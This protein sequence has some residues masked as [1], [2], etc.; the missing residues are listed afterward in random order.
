MALKFKKLD[1]VKI[2]VD[3]DGVFHVESPDWSKKMVRIPTDFVIGR[4]GVKV[5]I[6]FKDSE[7]KLIFPEPHHVSQEE[8]LNAEIVKTG[9]KSYRLI[10]CKFWI[11]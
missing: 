9:G 8:L 7:G 2:P 5:Q 1:P 4:E 11:R 3:D 10:D 6:D